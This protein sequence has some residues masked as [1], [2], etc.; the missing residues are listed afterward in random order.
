MPFN[1]REYEWA[2]ITVIVGGVDRIGIRSFKYAEKREKEAIYAKGRKP[3]SIQS[4]NDAFDCELGF[5]QSELNQMEDA[6]TTGSILDI[7]VDIEFSY[8][9]P[10]NAIRTDRMEGFQFTE[11]AKELKQGDKFMDFKAGGIGLNLV[12]NV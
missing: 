8:G 7:A 6:S 9:T 3:H 1:S 10:P 11:A 4:G 5:L 2:D 12:K